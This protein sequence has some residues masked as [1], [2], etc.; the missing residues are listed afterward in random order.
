MVIFHHPDLVHDGQQWLLMVICGHPREVVDKMILVTHA[1]TT[2][3]MLDVS[4]AVATN[5]AWI[6]SQ[7]F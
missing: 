4:R 6:G 1:S 3:S 5:H 2:R 7:V